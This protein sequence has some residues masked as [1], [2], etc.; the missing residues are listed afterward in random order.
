MLQTKNFSPRQYQEAI[1]NTCKDNNTLVVLETGLGKT[2]IALMLFS[3]P[4]CI[5][6]DVLNSIISLQDTS[7]I[8]FDEAHHAIQNYAY[9][10]I[11]KVYSQ[12]SPTPHILALTA[13][14]GSTGEKIKQL[15][16]NLLIKKTEIRTDQDEDV[17]PYIQDKKIQW[18]TI[19]LDTP[20][21][22]IQIGR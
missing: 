2:A 13:S 11:A 14:P 12:Q 22:N 17:K 4:Q 9:V 3:T 19:P 7:L 21:L 16:S 10:N 20:L 5:N 15:C 6:N 18:L 8:V 1:F